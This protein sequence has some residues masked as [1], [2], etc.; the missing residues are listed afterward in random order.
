MKVTKLCA[1]AAI[2]V[3]LFGNGAFVNAQV[4]VGADKTPE[5]F[6]VLELR[7]NTHNG[8]RLPQMTTEERNV[9]ADEDFRA[10]PEAMG[11]E[12]FNTETHC[13]E[14]WNGFAWISKCGAEQHS[15]DC[16]LPDKP[17]QISGTA[18]VINSTLYTYS[19][20][21]VPEATSYI[22]TVPLGWQI[23]GSMFG[24][25]IE[26]TSTTLTVTAHI[27]LKMDGTVIQVRAKN[28]CG[29]SEPCVLGVSPCGA[30]DGTGMRAFMCYNLG[31]TLNGD[32]FTP[33]Q[34]LN[35]DYYQWGSDEPFATVDTPPGGITMPVAPTTWYGSSGSALEVNSTE[36]SAT[37]PCPAGYRIPNKNEW[38]GVLNI[39]INSQDYMDATYPWI[40]YADI[41]NDDVSTT[42][43]AGI[44][45]GDAL[46]LQA[47]GYREHVTVNDGRLYQRGNMGYYWS[48][49][50][51]DANNAYSGYFYD[52]CGWD[53]P[54][55]TWVLSS[56][57]QHAQSIRCI[58]Q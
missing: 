43:W 3:M 19:I 20:E 6:S 21:Q 29:E 17:K 49:T 12:I 37:D 48:S 8:L 5:D 38:N 33:S 54:N 13:V 25:N 57:R 9:M 41:D 7:S 39:N 46:F 22:W 52:W 28:A 18:V 11:L 16:P 42:T 30:N 47:A 15:D 55:Y 24:N 32:P 31:A 14:T 45:I 4:T 51:S 1:T 56:Y 26:T 36:K 27:N 50:L 2:A 58:A 34:D 35:G 23:S 44:K 40:P 10:N 53:T